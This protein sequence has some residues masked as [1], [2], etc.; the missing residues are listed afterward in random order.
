MKEAKVIKTDR[1]YQQHITAGR[2]RPEQARMELSAMFAEGTE[3][4][5]RTEQ[6]GLTLFALVE[7]AA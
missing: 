3:P 1:Q 6:P 2:L 5:S 4:V 7:A